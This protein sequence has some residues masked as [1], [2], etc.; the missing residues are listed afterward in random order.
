[1]CPIFADGLQLHLD[2]ILARK[3]YSAH[4]GKGFFD[5]LVRFI[6]SAPVIAMVLEGVNTVQIVRK[7]M[8]ETD[9]S[10]AAP[11]TIRG[12]WAQDIER[13]LIH[14]SADG[15]DATKE[16]SLFFSPEEIFSYPR[17]VDRWITSG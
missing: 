14:G 15:E 16:I 6:T 4:E 1:M 3:H 2:E 11:G 8:G 13:N 17:E 7:L 10:R 9:P 12:D 5:S